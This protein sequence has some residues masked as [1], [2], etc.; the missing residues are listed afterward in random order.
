LFFLFLFSFDSL[1]L[2]TAFIPRALEFLI[3]VTKVS[4]LLRNINGF[5]VSFAC[6]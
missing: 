2:D 3:L 1:L 5:C 4:S 6:F